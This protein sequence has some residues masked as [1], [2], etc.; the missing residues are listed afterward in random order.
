MNATMHNVVSKVP[1]VTLGFWIIKI[2]AT[3][4]GGDA[5]T[6][7]MNLGYAVGSFIFLGIFAFAV[8][9]Q[10][11][12][13]VFHPFLY[14]LTIVATTTLGTTMADFADRS[15]GIGYSGG[16]ALLFTGLAASL[17]IWL[18]SEGS[19]SVTTVA[20]PR[21]EIFYWVA[22][23]FSQT[24]GT[25]LGDWMA[26]TNGLGYEGGA[27]VF[28]VGLALVAAAYFWTEISHTLLF[29]AAFILTRPLGATLGDL[30][31]KP[32]DLGG[33]ALS[34]YYASAILAA[35]IIAGLLILPQKA[36]SHP[37]AQSKARDGRPRRPWSGLDRRSVAREEER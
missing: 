23:L 13:K 1:E 12:A 27:V 30:L 25:A 14:W 7:S 8:V 33:F 10:M 9:A 19:I 2:I 17:A 31:D 32:H 15:L 26:D 34:R 28:A 35:I 22:I 21:A 29:W 24:L 36:G 37:R 11:R 16:S 6:M 20:T 4:L 5:V 3:T 18:W